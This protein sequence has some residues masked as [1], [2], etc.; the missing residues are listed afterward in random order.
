M[1]NIKLKILYACSNSYNS[2]HQLERF[3]N[4]VKNKNYQI[5][6]AAYR[7]YMPNNIQTDWNL[8]SLLNIFDPNAISL[9]NPNFEYYYKQIKSYKPDLIISDSEYFTTSIAISLNKLIW[10]YSSS[11]IDFALGCRNIGFLKTYKFVF[12]KDTNRNNKIHYMTSNSNKA[13]VYSHL[14]DS[15]VDFDLKPSFEWVR[16]YYIKDNSNLNNNLTGITLSRNKKITSLL[17]KY[18]DSILYCHNDYENHLNLSIKNI[19][20][21]INYS[22]L[23]KC[24]LFIHEGYTDFFADALYNNKFSIIIP[25]FNC[26]ESIINAFIAEKYKFGKIVYNC[27]EDISSYIEEEV[28]FKYNNSVKFLHESIP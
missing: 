28:N 5:K 16:P 17:K 19:D 15:D 21:Y 3:V 24:N 22:N 26:A 12:V 6:V 7:K 11:Y 9:D 14:C 4:A 20:D 13:L 8:E 27:N 18:K 1:S 25:D 23:S 10:Q 2:K